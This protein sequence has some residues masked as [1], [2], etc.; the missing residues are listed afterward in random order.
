MSSIFS[1]YFLLHRTGLYQLGPSFSTRVFKNGV[2]KQ[3]KFTA[4][5][6]KARQMTSS[7]N[8][9]VTQV[10]EAFIQQTLVTHHLLTIKIERH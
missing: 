4:D 7:R 6:K 10:E 5:S 9:D 3:T 8:S 1:F 2:K